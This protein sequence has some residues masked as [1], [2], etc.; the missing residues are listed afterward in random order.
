MDGAPLWAG[1]PRGPSRRLEQ[2]MTNPTGATANSI[3]IEDIK[4]RRRQNILSMRRARS[5]GSAGCGHSDSSRGGVRRGAGVRAPCAVARGVVQGGRTE[6]A[7]GSGLGRAWRSL[8]GVWRAASGERRWDATP[9]GRAAAGPALGQI[10]DD[11]RPK[12]GPW[13]KRSG[14][15]GGAVRR[16]RHAGA[17]RAPATGATRARHE[18]PPLALRGRATSARH[19]RYAGAPRAPATGATRARHERP[20]LLSSPRRVVLERRAIQSAL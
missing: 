14:A 15:S 2:T 6:A 1:P 12:S 8:A 10:S 16:R 19:W 3:A 20:P 5:S 13:W 9:S 17:P 4:E 11:I 7:R 18:R